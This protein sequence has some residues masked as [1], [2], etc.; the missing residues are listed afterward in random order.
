[1]NVTDFAALH[2]LSRHAITKHWIPNGMPGASRD[3]AGRVN[4]IDE[5]VASA[6]LRQYRVPGDP[7][8]GMG[9]NRGNKHT[10]RTPPPA[11]E[12]PDAPDAPNI[13]EIP[14]GSD[15][16]VPSRAPTENDSAISLAEA[17]RLLK[18]EEW[19]EQK[20]KN[21]QREGS[22]MNREDAVEAWGVLLREFAQMLEN[23]MQALP[24]ELTRRLDLPGSRQVEAAQVVG[25]AV[26]AVQARCRAMGEDFARAIV[27]GASGD[28]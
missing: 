2:G 19:R 22:L 4:E 5:P 14:N 7:H 15:A 6:W 27:T 3:K 10:K 18:L 28:A 12:A 24:A 25:D 11:P 17:T 1:M 21:E 8:T 26:R 13:S 20:M 16:A 23:V 9:G